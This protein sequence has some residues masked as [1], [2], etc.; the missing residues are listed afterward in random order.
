[1][2]TYEIVLFLHIAVVVFA[3]GVAAVLHTALFRIRRAGSPREMSA[4]LPILEKSEP[5]FPISAVL[6]LGLGGWLIQLSDDVYGWG[7]GWILTAIITLVIVEIVGGAVL[8]PRV[9]RL[10][11]AIESDTG[12]TV[13]EATRTAAVNPVMWYSGHFTTGAV[14]GI[15]M[16]MAA[17]P[18]TATSIAVVVVGALAG[19]ASAVPFAKPLTV[20]SP[21]TGPAV[22]G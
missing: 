3:F 14:L 13:S 10:S 1:M 21:T 9:K 4:W 19:V 16:L 15:V 11:A 6:L 12:E 17:K 5:L 18:S 20:A 8:G 7:D 2:S 22:S